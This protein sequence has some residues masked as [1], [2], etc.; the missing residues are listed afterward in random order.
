MY[1]N[2]ILAALT[3]PRHLLVRIFFFLFIFLGVWKYLWK[4]H[5][6]IFFTNSQDVRLTLQPVDVLVHGWV[7][8]NML[9][10]IWFE[11][12]HLWVG[13]RRFYCWIGSPRSR[14]EQSDKTW[15]SV[16]WQ[17]TCFY[18]I[19]VRNFWIPSTRGCGSP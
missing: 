16:L 11:F 5:M 1:T 13:D 7:E 4:I 18:P 10:W 9:V 19:C 6:W 15:E 17:S 14:F 8:A 12:L 2:W 3:N